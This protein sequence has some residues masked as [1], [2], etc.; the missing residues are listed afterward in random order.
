GRSRP[1]RRARRTRWIT[2]RRSKDACRGEERAAA[3][4]L[5]VIWES[6]DCSC[7]RRTMTALRACVLAVASFG[8]A[9]PAWAD[10]PDEKPKV[11]IEFRRAE[12]KPADGLTEAAVPGGK[13]KIYLHKTPDLTNED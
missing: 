11:K 2:S 5:L 3:R 12:T 4:P 6:P 8:F 1:S 13:E 7:G 9:V 10:K